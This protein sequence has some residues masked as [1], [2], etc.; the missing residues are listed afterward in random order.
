MNLVTL[1]EE[2]ST[3]HEQIPQTRNHEP[4]EAELLA[5]LGQFTPAFQDDAEDKEVE[6]RDAEEKDAEPKSARGSKASFKKASGD[7]TIASSGDASFIPGAAREKEEEDDP[8]ED[9]ALRQ[10]IQ[11]SR[12]HVTE[13]AAA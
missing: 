3:W 2:S 7:D 6:N 8:N 4:S 5:E 11:I 13:D 10:K 1:L 9:N 12:D